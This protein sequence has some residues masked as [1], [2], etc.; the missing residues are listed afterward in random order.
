MARRAVTYLGGD[1]TSLDSLRISCERDE[2]QLNAVLIALL[3][4]KVDNP[5][6][7]DI[8]ATIAVYERQPVPPPPQA[9]IGELIMITTG[10]PPAPSRHIFDGEAQIGTN[11]GPVRVFKPQ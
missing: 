11:A 7:S 5:T 4:G 2:A 8:P 1:L 10:N 3:V 6:G 9:R